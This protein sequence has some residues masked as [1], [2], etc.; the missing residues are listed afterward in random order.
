MLYSPKPDAL[1]TNS[2]DSSPSSTKEAK[3][4]SIE[5]EKEWLKACKRRRPTVVDDNHQKLLA[6]KL[7]LTLSTKKELDE[8]AKREQALF[9]IEK[10]KKELE[11]EMMALQVLKLKKDLGLE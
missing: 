4:R 1:Q 8:K 10:R 7:E 5:E 6:A 3:K 9:E 2:R 11:A